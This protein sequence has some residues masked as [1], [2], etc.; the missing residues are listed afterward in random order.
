MGK[1]AQ[2]KNFISKRL[3]RAILVLPLVRMHW[4]LLGAGGCWK[5]KGKLYVYFRAMGTKAAPGK[6]ELRLK[7]KNLSWVLQNLSFMD[8]SAPLG[9]KEVYKPKG[10]KVSNPGSLRPFL[11][12]FH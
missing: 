12:Y 11:S 6:R 2:R 10:Q 4:V 1:A 9:Q 5:R 7:W 3:K 8:F